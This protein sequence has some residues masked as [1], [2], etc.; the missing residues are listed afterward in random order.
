MDISA[1]I[2]LPTTEG[3]TALLGSQGQT[4]LHP[5]LSQRHSLVPWETGSV[6]LAIWSKTSKTPVVWGQRRCYSWPE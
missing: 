6:G 3:V 2:I 1:T 4:V 5:D